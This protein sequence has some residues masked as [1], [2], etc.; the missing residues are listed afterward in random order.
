MATV[1]FKGL[2]FSSHTTYT[3]VYD[4]FLHRSTVP[5]TACC[6]SALRADWWKISF[7]ADAVLAADHW[8]TALRA[9]FWDLQQLQR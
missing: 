2:K 8:S 9:V 7:S 6:L 1:G 3:H 5:W 4:G